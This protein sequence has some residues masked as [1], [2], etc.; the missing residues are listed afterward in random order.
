MTKLSG[1][2]ERMVWSVVASIG[3]DG[4]A[5]ESNFRPRATRNVLIRMGL[6][7]VGT[8]DRIGQVRATQAARDLV[9][10][11]STAQDAVM[12]RTDVVTVDELRAANERGERIGVYMDKADDGTLSLRRVPDDVEVPV[13][14][15]MTTW[16][17]YCP[18]SNIKPADM[19]ALMPDGSVTPMCDDVMCRERSDDDGAVGYYMPVGGCAELTQRRVELAAT[20]YSSAK[21]HQAY[22]VVLAAYAAQVARRLVAEYGETAADAESLVVRYAEDVARGER[23]GSYIDYVA[24]NIAHAE[25]ERRTQHTCTAPYVTGCHACELAAP[26]ACEECDYRTDTRDALDLHVERE[27][28]SGQTEITAADIVGP[29]LAKYLTAEGSPKTPTWIMDEE[30]GDLNDAAR[31]G[32]LTPYLTEHRPELMGRWARTGGCIRHEGHVIGITVPAAELP[33]YCP[34]QRSI[35]YVADYRGHWSG[36]AWLSYHRYGTQAHRSEVDAI[37]WCRGRMDLIVVPVPVP[38]VDDVAAM[39]GDPVAWFELLSPVVVAPVRLTRR[40]GSRGSRGSR[41]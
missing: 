37:R 9:S 32:S 19:D 38:T 14:D 6:M 25:H 28:A 27:H 39:A 22:A 15:A 35:R 36:E 7:E 18:P 21:G 20:P 40:K 24:W 17:Q 34:E 31:R 8:G 33:C 26:V 2:Q 3:P 4:W 30:A 41:R 16:C 13:G 12:G 23:F 5:W 11:W 29:L 10:Q 1:A